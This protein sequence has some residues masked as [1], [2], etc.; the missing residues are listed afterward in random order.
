M[1]FLTNLIL[2]HL[3]FIFSISQL[4][5]NDLIIAE[6]ET[7]KGLVVSELFWEETPMTVA[8][9][10]LLAEGKL[11]NQRRGKPFYDGLRFHQVIPK[12]M[13]MTGCPENTGTGRLKYTF[14]DEIVHHLK[15]DKKGLLVMDTQGYDRNSCRFLI[16]LQP[17]DFLSGKKT[18][19]G[20]VISDLSLL[21]TLQKGDHIKKVSIKRLGART[22]NFALS[23]KDFIRIKKDF[24]ERKHQLE[25]NLENMIYRYAK[26]KYPNHIRTN[27]GSRF[28]V[29]KKS[30]ETRTPKIGDR[31]WIRFTGRL[32]N[33]KVFDRNIKGAPYEFTLGQQKVVPVWEEMVPWMKIG[34]TRTIVTPPKMAFGRQGK[35]EFVR[36]NTPVEYDITLVKIES[37]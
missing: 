7:S 21:D 1:K 12:L 26:E 25:V 24:F 5:S 3:I 29:A 35:G 27:S 4:S 20:R 9:F 19:F 8:H 31:V 13:A 28:I 15:I 6:I 22:Q 2:S 18:V 32:L 14:P 37:R 33:G 36:P 23:E 11:D 17:L 34:E 16:T 30:Q 10:I